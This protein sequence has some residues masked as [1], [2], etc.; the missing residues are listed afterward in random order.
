MA[1]IHTMLKEKL[2]YVTEVLKYNNTRNYSTQTERIEEILSRSLFNEHKHQ[3]SLPTAHLN[4]S[5]VIQL[6]SRRPYRHLLNYIEQTTSY[7]VY[8]CLTLILQHLWKV[9]LQQSAT[10]SLVMCNL[11]EPVN[12]C[13]MVASVSLVSTFLLPR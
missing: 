13:E 6:C 8:Y 9:L 3:R 7:Y 2:Q 1:L 5:T 11:C 4:C 12:E 10:V